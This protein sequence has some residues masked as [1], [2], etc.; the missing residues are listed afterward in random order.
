MNRKGKDIVHELK[1]IA[2]GLDLP[3][4]PPYRAPEGYFD[5]LP[6]QVLQRVR[7]TDAGTGA[8][9]E[10]LEALSP[11]LGSIPR[12]QPL[13]VPQGY[14]EGLPGRIL[15][16][17]ASQEAPAKVV[18]IR[19]RRRYLAWVAAACFIGFLGLGALF[20]LRQQSTTTGTRSLEMQLAG[21]SDQ[22]IIDYLQAHSD[23]FDNEAIISGVSNAV[24][25]D[26]LPR[27]STNLNDLPP[28][29]IENYL[30][31]AGWSN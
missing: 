24:A 18:P 25:T 10:E 26:E 20:L 30:E 22:E 29:A 7:T 31:S 17:I 1:E 21:I 6:E 15:Q 28:D 4:A 8:V 2:P 9:Q 5:A 12:Q 23:A 16:G 3:S 11:L 13:S 19:S 27:I 14:F